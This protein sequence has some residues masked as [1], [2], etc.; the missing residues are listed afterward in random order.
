VI[1]SSLKSGSNAFHGDLFEYLR[2][3]I[4]DA[5]NFFLPKPL[6][7]QRNQFGGT[8]GG[9]IYRNKIFFFADYQGTRLREG[10]SFNDVVP[11]AM[12]RTGNFSDLAKQLTNPLTGQSFA[13]NIIPPSLISPQANYLLQYMPLPNTLQ[14]ST[15]RSVFASNLPENS[16]EG[17][18]RLDINAT[19]RD[20]MMARYSIA[21]NNEFDP[22]PYPAL[23]GTDLHSKAQDVTLRWTHLFTPK[24]LNVAQASYYDSPFVFGTVLPGVDVD[25]AA[26]IQGFSNPVITPFQ[27]FPLINISGYQGYQG[28]P[29]DQRPKQP[30]SKWPA[31]QD[32]I[33]Y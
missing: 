21:D 25:A 6:Q 10:Q 28:S 12:E 30:V 1:N 18:V 33:L 8:I 24:L 22:N 7:L 2:N 20:S 16:D 15:S 4:F 13:G 26:G 32:R 5:R 31:F 11:S 17:D 19:E 3:N 27:S 14:G 29:S 9:P 23:Q